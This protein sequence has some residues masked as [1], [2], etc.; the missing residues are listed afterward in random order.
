VASTEAA[1]GRAR[2]ATWRLRGDVV[3]GFPRPLAV[4]I[5]NVTDD[6]FYLG[7]RSGT[8]DRAVRDG[9]AMTQEGFDL[10]DVG[11]VAAA[12]GPPVPADDEAQRLVPAIRGLAG[13]GRVPVIADTF[14]PPVAREALDAGAVAINDIGGGQDPA[15]LE[16]AAETGCGIVLMHIEGPPRQ[17]RPPPSYDD[18]VAHLRHWF[19]ERIGEARERGVS[20]DQIALDPGFDFDLSVDDDIEVL[21]RLDELRELGRPLF[22]SLSRKDFLGAIVGGSWE[23]RVSAE[24]REWATLAAVTLA[25]SSG[26]QLFRLHD[27]SAVDAMRVS[28]RIVNG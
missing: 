23:R 1:H 12:P 14:A 9:L 21:A 28:H 10:L 8:A 19:A 15:M 2:H 16:L 3:L 5:V 26:A 27:R 18:P 17:D 11:A 6:S 13:T 25:V 22:V 20:E 7:A 24:D 4:G